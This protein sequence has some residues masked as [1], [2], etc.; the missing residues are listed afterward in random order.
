MPSNISHKEKSLKKMQES[1]PPHSCESTDV[2]DDLK[3]SS[4]LGLLKGLRAVG[5]GGLE[6]FSDEP[7]DANGLLLFSSSCFTAA[8]GFFGIVSRRFI[9]ARVFPDFDLISSS[10]TGCI[11]SVALSKVT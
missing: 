5:V 6:I 4:L 1:Y 9:N 3:E 11:V 2:V 10:R 7:A 8:V